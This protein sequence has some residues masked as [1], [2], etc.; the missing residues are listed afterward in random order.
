[1]AYNTLDPLLKA[2]RTVLLLGKG[3]TKTPDIFSESLFVS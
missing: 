2:I 1:M 3:K